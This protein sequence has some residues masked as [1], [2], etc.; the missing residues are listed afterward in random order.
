VNRQ[1]LVKI[2]LILAATTLP[3]MLMFLVTGGLY[4]AEYKPSSHKQ[5]YEVK[6]EKPLQADIVQLKQVVHQKLIE[7]KLDDPNGKARLKRDKKRGGKKFVWSGSNHTVTMWSHANDRSVVSIEI[8]T[9]SW[10]KR[11]MKLHKGKGG[12]VFDIFA[13]VTAIVL[14]L[15][16]FT[17]VWIGLQSMAYRKLT[18]TALGSGSLLFVLLVLYAQ[19]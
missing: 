5:T 3:I 14:I 4:T 7:L 1:L 19:S 6:L 9:P 8:S 11:L 16:L 15:V 17:G 10:Y 13:I 12:D 2:H 18:W